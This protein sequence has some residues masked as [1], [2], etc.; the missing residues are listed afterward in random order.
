MYVGPL[1]LLSLVRKNTYVYLG[2]P[3]YWSLGFNSSAYPLA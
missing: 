1:Y 2:L 3:F